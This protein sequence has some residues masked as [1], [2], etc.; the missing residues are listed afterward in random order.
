MLVSLAPRS[1]SAAR[2]SPRL[3]RPRLEALEDRYAPA[4]LS[5][6]IDYALGRNVTL[7]GYLTNTSTPGNQLINIQGMVNGQVV[8]DSAGHYSL[9]ATAS[10]LGQVFA[11]K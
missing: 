8:T 7:S 1:R 2:P 4:T 11:Q 10:G 3:A 6:Q 9:S 5:L